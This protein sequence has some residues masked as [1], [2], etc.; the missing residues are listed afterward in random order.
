M[1]VGHCQLDKTLLTHC[2]FGKALQV[3]GSPPVTPTPLNDAFLS[4]ETSHS[5]AEARPA[6]D[7]SPWGMGRCG[8]RHRQLYRSR[9]Q[10]WPVAHSR[11]AVRTVQTAA[12]P[13]CGHGGGAAGGM[14]R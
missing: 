5:S 1:Y 4:Q 2:Q 12:V 14:R 10:G 11:A 13:G 8:T 3:R 6:T 7:D 9:A